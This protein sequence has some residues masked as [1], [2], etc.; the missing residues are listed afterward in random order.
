MENTHNDKKFTLAIGA[1]WEPG[2]DDLKYVDLI[3][4][5]Y[6]KYSEHYISNTEFE[7]VNNWEDMFENYEKG[8]HKAA[9]D[10]WKKDAPK[11]F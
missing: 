5:S 11:E 6:E 8:I 10:Y 4:R 2:L 9:S 3:R 1:P 7:M